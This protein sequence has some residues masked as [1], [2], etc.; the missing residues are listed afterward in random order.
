MRPPIIAAMMTV[1]CLSATTARG[2]DAASRTVAGGQPC[3][4]AVGHPVRIVAFG[5]S[6]TYGKNLARSDA[7]P[8]QLEKLLIADGYTVTV[9]NEGVN[10]ITTREELDKLDSAVP[11]GTDIVIFQPGG[12]DANSTRRHFA[13]SPE[14]T[15]KNIGGIVQRL[16]ARKIGVVLSAGEE[17]REALAQLDVPM[18]DEWNHLVPPDEHQPDGQHLTPAGYGRVAQAVRPMVEQLICKRLAAN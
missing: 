4:A 5:G 10:G 14:E 15:E 18:I 8:A 12:N 17:K 16:Q 11:N 1:L 7:Y 9:K 3:A 13:L 2:Q 6:N